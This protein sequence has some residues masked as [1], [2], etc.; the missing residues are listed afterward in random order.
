ME[1]QEGILN[2]LLEKIN[3]LENRNKNLRNDIKN[4]KNELDNYENNNINSEK[5]KEKEEKEENVK[6]SGK[7]KINIKEKNENKK[8]AIPTDEED[9]K[10]GERFLYEIKNIKLNSYDIESN[11]K[12]V[13]IEYITQEQHSSLYIMGD[14]TKWEIMPMKKNKDIFSYKVVLLKGF[15]Y[16]YAFQAGDQIL[17]DYNNLYEDNP[18]NFQIQN[19]ID[20]SKNKE[21]SQNFD[22]EN[23]IN[24]LKMAQKNYFLS[25][26]NMDEEQLRFLD[27]FKRHIIA[28]KEIYEE[29][30][31]EHSK[32]TNSIYGYYDQ[33][34][35]YIQPYE[36]ESKITNLRLFFKDRIFAHYQE[37]PDAKDKPYKYYYKIVNINNNFCFQSIKLYDN[38][39]IKINYAYYNDIRY[40]YSIYF[41]S[42]SIEPISINS[43]LYH[44]L[45]KEESENI[46]KI[47]NN[48]KDSILKAYFKTLIGLRNYADT[49]NNNNNNINMVEGIRSYIRNYGSILVLPDRVEPKNINM[50][51]YEFQYSLNKIVKVRNKKEGSYVEYLAID[52]KAE[53]AKKP[54]RYKVYYCIKNNKFK[55]I[56]CHVLDKDLRNIKILIKEID[57]NIDPKTLKKNEE[58]IKNNQLL[59]IIKE[60]VPIK[61]YYNGKKVKMEGI[62]IDE[63]KLYLLLSSDPDSIFNKMYVTVDNIEEKL[64]YDLMEQCNEFSYSLD[65]ISNGVDVTVTYDNNKNYVVEKMMLAVSP[66]LLQKLTTYEENQLKKKQINELKDKQ[67][68]EM[69]KYF[70]ISQKMA[71][72][73]KYNKEA[74]DKMDKKEKD[75]LLNTLNEY[76]NNMINVL[77]YIENNEMWETIDEAVNIAAEIEDLIKLFQNK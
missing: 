53:K 37:N 63:N 77:T 74:I 30:L 15:K 55:I 8:M 42:I 27:K 76:K 71:D 29:K 59:L 5:E 41:D 32:L 28:S 35:K 43:K 50:N 38:N 48:N 18:K 24:I 40:Y 3:N 16:Y 7:N 62:K 52:E 4:K 65:N 67:M 31:L 21:K 1:D 69:E 26:L 13:T 58:Y 57:K 20:L 2:E 61:L 44:L 54:F 45:P 34:F 47:Y 9:K 75:N 56:H 49:Q 39:N 25:K 14:F 51:D 60:T 11:I 19:Y 17:I 68:S 6:E 70:V 64:N 10:I 23:D 22:Y 36:S 46:L 33:L 73:R 66:C 12:E 72:L